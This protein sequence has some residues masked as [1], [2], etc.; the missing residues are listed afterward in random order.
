MRPDS[1]WAT[2][3]MPCLV[4]SNP[5]HKPTY[6]LPALKEREAAALRA[7]IE[8]FVRRGGQIERVA[9]PRPNARNGRK[10]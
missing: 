8:A 2:V 4:S 9:T 7:D 10:A 6:V 5:Q 3:Q 1:G